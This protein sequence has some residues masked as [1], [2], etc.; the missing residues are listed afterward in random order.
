VGDPVALECAHELAAGMCGIRTAGDMV[1]RV[2][3]AK[4]L[5]INAAKTYVAEKLGVSVQDLSDSIIMSEVRENLQIGVIQPT[6]GAAINVEAK[7]H[8]EKI[9]GIPINCVDRFYE[10]AGLAK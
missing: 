9:L 7:I 5:K 6:D 3:L 2:Q 1:L 4:G 8:M 10:R